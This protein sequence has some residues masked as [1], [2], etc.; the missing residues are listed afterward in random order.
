MYSLLKS[1]AAS[2]FFYALVNCAHGA[3]VADNAKKANEISVHVSQNIDD[4][5]M[6]LIE[7]E[8]IEELES[9]SEEEIFPLTTTKG[10]FVDP[11]DA[12]SEVV[13]GKLQSSA[14][15]VKQQPRV[16]V[17]KDEDKIIEIDEPPHA[18][19]VFLEEKIFQPPFLFSCCGVA[20]VIGL[21]REK[22]AKPAEVVE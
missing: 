12:L 15:A 19:M 21:Y 5:S 1:I 3:S 14:G 17:S 4:P 18:A 7:A 22:I 10:F 2:I 6:N 11:E 20:F 13:E 9:L 8:E 16:D